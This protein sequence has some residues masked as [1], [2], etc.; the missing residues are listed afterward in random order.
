MQPAYV[1]R[2]N[3]SLSDGNACR[4]G[5]MYS[6]KIVTLITSNVSTS[7]NYT[8][9]QFTVSQNGMAKYRSSLMTALMHTSFASILKACART[10]PTSSFK[11]DTTY[12]TSRSNLMSSATCLPME[13]RRSN[14][15]I[16]E[17]GKAVFRMDEQRS[18]K[19]MRAPSSTTQWATCKHQ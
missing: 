4:A 19:R 9:M 5:K 3:T 6:E 11:H 7:S 14:A 2:T 10:S 1:D 17:E 15:C 18:D 13:S 16:F 12:G 8:R